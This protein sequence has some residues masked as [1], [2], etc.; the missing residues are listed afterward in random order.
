MNT[1][2]ITDFFLQGLKKL[3]RKFLSAPYAALAKELNEFEAA[4]Y[5]YQELPDLGARPKILIFK[6]DDIGDAVYALP[7]VK[8]LRDRFPD[9]EIHVICQKKTAP[10]FLASGLFDKIAPVDVR[11]IFI[12]FQSLDLDA[13]LKQLGEPQYDAAFFLRTYPAFFPLFQKL[14]ARLLIQPKDPRMGSLSPWQAYVSQWG[15]RRAHQAEQML[16]IVARATGEHYG[17][18]DVVFPKFTFKEKD[19]AAVEKTFGTDS[20]GPYVVIHPY[21]RFETRRYPYEYWRD[22]LSKLRTEFPEVKWVITGGK[23]DPS[24]GIPGVVEMQ[25]KL[26]L[27]ETGVLLSRATAF[28]GNESGPGHWA[29]AMGKPVVTL[30]S[31]HSHVSEWGVWGSEKL[32]V[33]KD[34]PCQN[35]Y[36]RAC[37]KEKVKCLTGLTPELIAPQIRDFLR[38]HVAAALA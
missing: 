34:V 2:A 5:L 32:N 8:K 16:E 29:A 38:G 26:R 30:L 10:I 15:K 20:P 36:L 1:I 3:E 18:A 21:A 31:G 35:C 28:L 23:E 24:L 33:K 25:G 27:G 17:D 9:A 37:P 22:L 7:A 13:A 4:G 11:A 12:R 6:P 19:L 14:P